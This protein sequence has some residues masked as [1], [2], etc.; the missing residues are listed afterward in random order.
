[1]SAAPL[2]KCKV[3]TYVLERIKQGY[4]YVLPSICVEV[5]KG[6]MTSSSSTTTTT[7]S[8]P[9][10]DFGDCHQVRIFKGFVFFFLPQLSPVLMETLF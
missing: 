3:C 5:Y 8:G 2:G 4:E 6:G 7:T 1:V 10:G 9:A